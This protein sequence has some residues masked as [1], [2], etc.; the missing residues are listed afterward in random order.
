L[1]VVSAAWYTIDHLWA[2]ADAAGTPSEIGNRK[3]VQLSEDLERY[4]MS[5]QH[6]AADIVAALRRRDPAA[7]EALLRARLLRF[8]GE[9]SPLLPV[10]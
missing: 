6:F 5:Y 8:R 1:T 9:I 10:R 3:V 7:V 4:Q 2:R